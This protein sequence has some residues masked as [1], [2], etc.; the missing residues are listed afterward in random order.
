MGALEVIGESSEFFTPVATDLIDQLIGQYRGEL[1][2]VHQAADLF[3][4]DMG[5]IVRYFL[6][7]NGCDKRGYSSLRAER[8][9]QRKGAVAALNAT[10]WS[11]ALALTDVLDVMPQNRRNDWH[12]QITE[13]ETPEFS[14]DTVR[15]TLYGLLSARQQFLAERVDGIFHNL[16]GE[17]VTNSPR[18]FGKR[19]I[20]AYILDANEM[21]NYCQVGYINDLRCV[22]AKFMGRDEPKYHA[23]AA[24]ISTLKSCW[25]KW[26]TTDGGA[27]R[28]RLYHKGTAHLE[29]HPDMAW[30]LN[31]ILAHLHPLAI[32]A[33]FRTK[34]KKTLKTVPLM[35]R[36]LPFAV[37]ETLSKKRFIAGRINTPELDMG[38][39][40]NRSE[41]P[42]AW[43]EACRV[44]EGIGGTQVDSGVYRFEYAAGAV[45]DEII[46]S[47]CIPD[48]VSHQ[49]YATPA[50][51]AQEAIA[52]AGIGDR[53]TCLEPSAGQGALAEFMPKD[54]T[55]CV[56]I[57]DLHC[58]VLQ[59]K[60]YTVQKAD[61]LAWGEGRSFSRVVMNPPFSDGR[62]QAHL[63]HAASMVIAGG[64]LVAILPDSAR[65]SANLPG[66]DLSFSRTFSNEFQGTS[67][68][69]VILKATKR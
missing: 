32:P 5:G 22:I 37:L 44:L 34:P 16:S 51:I 45:I 9:F 61:F 3:A 11:K 36:P 33:E 42:A 60:G 65:K 63:A 39:H 8:L 2:K 49:Y 54:R 15:P 23:S 12:K 48:K 59:A 46:V 19:M 69:V 40:Y 27:L 6:Q 17:H 13:M 68:S 24:L 66:F 52:W 67:I 28:I 56:E 14:E 20:I 4:G 26:V 35:L 38:R 1:E 18:G 50:N 31:R 43:D 55:L 30:R 21:T 57:S 62:W 64:C 58:K 41:N 7:G 10:Y 53:D 25:G 47:G 29:V